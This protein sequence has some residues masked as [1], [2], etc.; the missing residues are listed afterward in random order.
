MMRLIPHV[1][2][3]FYDNRSN[4]TQLPLKSYEWFGKGSHLQDLMN[5]SRNDNLSLT[6]DS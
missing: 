6:N 4:G 3:L 1:A 5:G 2:T